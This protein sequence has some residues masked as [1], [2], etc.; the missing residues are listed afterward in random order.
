MGK[1]DKLLNVIGDNN[2]KRLASHM[3]PRYYALVKS[4]EIA[5]DILESNNLTFYELLTEKK[6]RYESFLNYIETAGLDEC[7]DNVDYRVSTKDVINRIDEQLS[8]EIKQIEKAYK[9]KDEEYMYADISI[10]IQEKIRKYD[11]IKEEYILENRSKKLK[12]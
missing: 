2:I 3:M 11:R 5:R 1:E 12:R 4:E 7:L 6:K 9:C 8:Y 10:I